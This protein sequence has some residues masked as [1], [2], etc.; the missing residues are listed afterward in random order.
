MMLCIIRFIGEKGTAYTLITSK[1]DKFAG[2]LVRNL[3]AS[4][5]P[6]PSELLSLAMQVNVN[7]NK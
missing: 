5:Q 4:N 3:E 2:D 6:V 7:N 1:E